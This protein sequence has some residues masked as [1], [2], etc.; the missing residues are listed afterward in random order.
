VAL[1]KAC[2]VGLLGSCDDYFD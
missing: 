1:L 2:C